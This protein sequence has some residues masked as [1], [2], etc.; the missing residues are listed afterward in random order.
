MVWNANQ[1]ALYSAVERYNSGIADT[2]EPRQHE[3]TKK[4][5][6]RSENNVREKPQETPKKPGAGYPRNIPRR[7]PLEAV[8]YDRDMLL[9]AALIIIL[10]HEKADSRLI[11]AL[12]FVLIM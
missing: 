11:A 12:A 1:S 3:K 5:E 6:P 10:I 8:F 2:H 7:N 4:P 9:I